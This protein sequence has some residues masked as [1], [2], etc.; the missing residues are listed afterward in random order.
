MK[1]KLA[2]P[3]RPRDVDKII[4]Y[5]GQGED[6]QVTLT[7]KQQELHARLDRIDRWLMKDPPSLV[8]KK[9]E[10]DFGVSKSKAY[11]LI[12][13]SRQ[14]YNSIS[15]ASDPEFGQRLIME[16]AYEARE[17]AIRR[18]DTRALVSLIKTLVDAFGLKDYDPNAI[19]PSDLQQH[20]YVLQFIINKQG[21]KHRHN[22]DLDD[23]EDIPHELLEEVKND[24]RENMG[25][26][27]DMAALLEK[28]EQTTKQA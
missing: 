23:V 1:N 10:N 24:V 14:V 7:A 15:Q 8:V 3:G 18:K 4:Q 12:D 9:I 11:R 27:D 26:L 6:Q 17:L 5:L 16:W 19:D 25:G 22:I 28:H 2:T 21:S 20:K 13:Y